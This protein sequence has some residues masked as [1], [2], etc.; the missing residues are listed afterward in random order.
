MS[1]I[2]NNIQILGS[3]YEQWSGILG[4]QWK[5]VESFM[6]GQILNSICKNTLSEEQKRSIL[7]LTNN[8]V[9]KPIMETYRY[10]YKFRTK[11]VCFSR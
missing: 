6:T 3:S 4:L 8:P 2:I 10:V 7:Q 1:S 5:S 9:K 11:S